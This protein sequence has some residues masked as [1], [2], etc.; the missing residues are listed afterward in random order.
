MT[1]AHAKLGKKLWLRRSLSTYRV[2][3]APD[4]THEAVE[5]VAPGSGRRLWLRPGWMT[6]RRSAPPEGLHGYIAVDVATRN[7]AE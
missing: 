3:A 5:V 1:D 7:A 6:C 2:T 4:D